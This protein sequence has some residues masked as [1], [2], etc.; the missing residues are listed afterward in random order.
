[1]SDAKRPEAA[2][3]GPVV[4]MRDV[5]KSYE[6]A[7]QPLHAVRGISFAVGRGEHVAIIGPSG[8]GKSTLLNLIGCLDRPTSGLY[9]LNGRDVAGLGDDELATLRNRE[10]GFVFQSFHLMSRAT[11]RE[12][13][14]LPLVYAGTGSGEREGRSEE[15]LRMVGLADRMDHLPEQLSGGEKQRVAI[16]RALVNRPSLVLAD[17]PTGNLDTATGEGILRLFETLHAQGN[18]LV[19]V[20]HDAGIAGRAQ[21]VLTVRDGKI[22]GP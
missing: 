7:G 21:R 3:G 20:T 11:A 5:W 17:E 4:L 13:V 22:E 14:A 6:M 18:T 15:A 2:A 1:M 16:A 19:T 8:S 9:L 12:N 10:I